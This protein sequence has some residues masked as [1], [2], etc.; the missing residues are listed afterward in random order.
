M[1]LDHFCEVQDENVTDLFGCEVWKEC[2]GIEDSSARRQMLIQLY[3]S[4][5]KAGGAQFVLPFEMADQ[6]GNTI[7]HLIFAT[8]ALKGMEVM[9]GAMVY[10]DKT[11]NYRFA[12]LV[13]QEQKHLLQFGLEETWVDFACHNIW[14][15]FS[16]TVVMVKQVRDYVIGETIYP[17]RKFV[18]KE[19]MSLDPPAIQYVDQPERK[20]TFPDHMRIRFQTYPS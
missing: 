13:P 4:Q 3:G 2:R 11:M 9:K 12:D 5:L 15:R 7:Y 17:F 19:L 6:H 20:M 10:V 16:G 14:E 18:L 1:D 8:N